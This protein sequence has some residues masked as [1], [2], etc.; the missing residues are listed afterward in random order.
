VST[1]Q[2]W[3][4][5]RGG[6]I[7]IPAGATGEYDQATVTGAPGGGAPTGSV[8]FKLY[9]SAACSQASLVLGTTSTSSLNSSGPLT[10]ASTA[11]A[12]QLA[13]GT[14]YWTAAYSGDSAYLPSATSCGAETLTVQ[15]RAA[16]TVSTSQTW[17]ST[18]GGSI[19]IPAG[20]TG[21]YDFASVMGQLGGLGSPTGTLT[22]RLYRQ[23]AS[24]PQCTGN[25][26]FSNVKSTGILGPVATSDPVTQQLAPGTYYWTAAYSGNSA[27]QP[28][29][30]PCGS[31]T[32]TIA[33]VRIL[34]AAATIAAQVLTLT[35]SCTAP[36]CTA[37][38]TITLLAPPPASDARKQAR[39]KPP[40][41]TLARGK[42][43]IRKRG[44]HTVRLRPTAAGRRFVASHDG[45]VTVNA[46][47]TMTIAGH[48]RVLK[49]H[50]KLKIIKPSK[51]QQR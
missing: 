2:T 37:R 50:L 15:P 12:Q 31:Q 26:V 7:T 47:L 6:S 28:S 22:F 19:T 33:P 46:A 21:E 44:K 16:A 39:I 17:N 13:P 27:Y 35:T 25:P 4:S 3:N 42:V 30:S 24:G 29:T 18:R 32:L 9:S 49:Q 8:T 36:P 20:A 1:S 11:V 10:A 51:H 48:A 40:V 43:T 38:I 45:Q 5:T 23:A 14:Y 34:R 41:I